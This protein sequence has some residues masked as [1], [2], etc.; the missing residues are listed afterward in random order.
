MFADPRANHNKFY[1]II[2]QDNGS[3]DVNYG[4]VGSSV[5][6]HHYSA[7]EKDFY[8]L[9][10]QKLCKGY[11]DVTLLHTENQASQSKQSEYHDYAKIENKRVDKF[12]KVMFER[13]QKLVENNYL[14]PTDV[15]QKMIDCA[16]LLISDLR[17]GYN[18]QSLKV[19]EF[20]DTL[21]RLFNTIPRKMGNVYDFIAHSDTDFEKII[22]REQDLVDALESVLKQKQI[23]QPQNYN[24]SKNQT[25]VEANGLKVNPVSYKEEDKIIAKLKDDCNN[26]NRYLKAVKIENIKTEQAFQDFVAG[27]HNKRTELLWHGSPNKNWWSIATNGLDTK[28][29]N[30]NC[31]FGAGI[32]FAPKSSKS[33]G[34]MSTGS[35][36]RGGNDNSGYLALFEVAVGKTL[37]P[38]YTNS[39]SCEEALRNLKNKGNYD[40]VW[41][42]AGTHN[43]V[44]L[45]NDEVIVYRNEQQT[46]RYLVEINNVARHFNLDITKDFFN[47]KCFD[48]LIKT[49]NKVTA[50]LNTDALKNCVAGTYFDK[51]NNY[52]F[53]ISNNYLT[54]LENGKDISK[55]FSN[56]DLWFITRELKKQFFEYEEDYEA[57]VNGKEKSIFKDG[58]E[59][60]LEEIEYDEAR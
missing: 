7:W 44:S 10:S 41:A 5:M 24:P 48:A 35:F 42:K 37:L 23:L 60:T 17:Q 43:G 33:A 57:F 2:E 58:V 29:G 39:W 28:Y 38:P 16:K 34:Y 47:E 11:E 36:W 13:Q 12:L 54:V 18:N 8:T 22:D 15:N 6:H 31:M 1:E 55:R 14:K 32:Y 52:S 27:N 59:D 9:K 53:S 50:C 30:R 46:I 4:R 21:K 40:S 51:N 56:D 45:R 25:I 26:Q 20:N 19:W 49:D 3:I